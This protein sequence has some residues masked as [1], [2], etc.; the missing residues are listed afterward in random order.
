MTRHEQKQASVVVPTAVVGPEGPEVAGVLADDGED[1]GIDAVAHGEVEIVERLARAAQR[2]LDA[3]G[4][5]V[6]V[7]ES[8][9]VEAGAAAADHLEA[10]ISE[11]GF[12]GGLPPPDVVVA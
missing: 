10:F 5:D 12:S 6:E 7:G 1:G 3:T 4:R 8:E 11:A 9:V 2:T